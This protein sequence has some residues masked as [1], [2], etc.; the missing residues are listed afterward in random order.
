[1]PNYKTQKGLDNKLDFAVMEQRCVNFWQ[2][3]NV[4]AYDKD[5]PRDNTYVVDTPPPTVSGSLHIGHIMSY[6]QTDI[7]VRWQRM[8][9]K[10][11]FYPIGWDDNGLP[12]E[13]RVQ[14]YMVFH[15]MRLYHMMNILFQHML[16]TSKNCDL[17]R[18]VIL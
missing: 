2:V 9:G 15:V 11:I 8:N 14:N 17:Y 18:V 12:T 6:T 7:M 5:A 1:M 10:A 13:R 4:Y 3:N 16:K